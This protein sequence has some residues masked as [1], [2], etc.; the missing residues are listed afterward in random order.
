MP[1]LLSDKEPVAL[2][3]LSL[4]YFTSTPGAHPP[5]FSRQYVLV[6]QFYT[7]LLQ[8]I[9]DLKLLIKIFSSGGNQALR[10][11]LSNP[12][13]LFSQK[14]VY[15]ILSNQPPAT[16][17]TDYNMPPFLPPF[18]YTANIKASTTYYLDVT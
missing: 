1:S 9:K 2:L 15:L 14:F 12:A 4:L 17:R 16:R 8:L 13:C 6:E 3:Y 7:R 5:P 10:L 18:L 11:W